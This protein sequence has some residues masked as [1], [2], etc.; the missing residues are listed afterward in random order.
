MILSK[1]RE[2]V[3]AFDTALPGL[4]PVYTETYQEVRD[5]AWE[6]RNMNEG[7]QLSTAEIAA[8]ESITW[9]EA[10]LAVQNETSLLSFLTG[11]QS[12]DTARIFVE[13]RDIDIVP[14]ESFPSSDI[15]SR[16][17]RGGSAWFVWHLN[18][19]Y[20]SRPELVTTYS[21]HFAR[22]DGVQSPIPD[23]PVDKPWFD[24]VLGCIEWELMILPDGRRFFPGRPVTGAEFIE[25]IQAV[26]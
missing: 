18:A 24:S 26:E 21:E 17:L 22:L 11:G 13:L 15:D 6:L 25:T 8:K 4:S 16:V 19:V 10:I 2:A 1:Y 14:P 20:N 9:A 12:W 3:A 7:I 23:V 5:G